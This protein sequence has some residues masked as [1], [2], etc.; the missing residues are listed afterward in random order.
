MFIKKF[1][2]SSFEEGLKQIKSELGP[3]ALIVKTVRKKSGVFG[4]S[5]IEITAATKQRSNIEGVEGEK[6]P[7]EEGSS[8]FSLA[9]VFPHRVKGEQTGKPKNTAPVKYIDVGDNPPKE[10]FLI[11]ARK[12]Y[13]EDFTRLGIS[14]SLAGELAYQANG[15]RAFQKKTSQSDIDPLAM[16]LSRKIKAIDLV[17]LSKKNRI[18]MVGTAGSGK[19]MAIIKLA[20]ELKKQNQPVVI[21]SLDSRKV[22]SSFEL[23][24]YGK[25]LK[26]PV[27]KIDEVEGREIQLVD[28]PSL[29]LD[30]QESNWDLVK[31][32]GQ[33]PVSCIL[34]LEATLRLPEMI[35]IL[36]VSKRF[37]HVDGIFVTKLDLATLTGVIC[38]LSHQTKIPICGINTSQSFN[39]PLECL[40][41]TQLGQ[42]IIQRG[43]T[44]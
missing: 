31:R 39:T 41:P 43:V 11:Q 7:I 19:T 23:Q 15:D 38:E 22:C 9:Q 6:M 16:I 36:E 40:T 30:S 13:A 25:I 4:K 44:S 28:T 17:E 35:R 18:A 20:L 29:R 2:V 3:D 34:C 21:S 5:Q 37:F 24:Q 42:M 33:K 32:L 1:I 26:V 14:S 8:R 10:G 27:K 12:R